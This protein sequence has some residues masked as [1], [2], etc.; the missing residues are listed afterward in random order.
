MDLF[1]KTWPPS[2]QK[3]HF[4][5]CLMVVEVSMAF[6][7]EQ[8]LEVHWQVEEYCEI[9][10]LEKQRSAPLVAV[11]SFAEGV[12]NHY[13]EVGGHIHLEDMNHIHPQRVGHHNC[14]RGV[15][16]HIHHLV[17]VELRN[18]LLEAEH[19]SHLLSEDIL[20]LVLLKQFQAW[21][22]DQVGSLL[23]KEEGNCQLAGS[24]E[25]GDSHQELEDNQKDTLLEGDILVG[26]G[27]IHQPEEGIHQEGGIHQPEDILA[28]QV[29]I[30]HHHHKEDMTFFFKEA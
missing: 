9:Q 15:E 8:K 26:Q 28:R 22:L 12:D 16:L 29:D 24:L 5:E 2:E 21:H 6:A 19:H 27:G 4:S 18:L 10:Q 1:S 13:L 30:L 25:N 14:L 17:E 20:N 7:E 23:Q 11:H 3:V